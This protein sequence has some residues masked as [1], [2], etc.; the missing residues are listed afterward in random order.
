MQL[1]LKNGVGASRDSDPED[2]RKAKT[3]LNILGELKPDPELGLNGFVDR[4][5]DTVVRRFQ[6]RRGLLVTGEIQPGDETEEAINAELTQ[7]K[8]KRGQVGRAGKSGSALIS[9]AVSA[10]DIDPRRG[11][12]TGDEDE[13]RFA[14]PAAGRTERR[15]ST[16]S[17]F[18]P[19]ANAV[20][21]ILNPEMRNDEAGKGW[22]GAPRQGGKKHKGVDLLAPPG[23]PVLSPVDGLIKRI[24]DPYLPTNRLHGKFNSVWIALPNG[25]TI[26]M[27][28]V[29]PT[30][31]EGDTVKG[32]Q[33][34]GIMQDRA[35]QTRDMENHVHV[36]VHDPRGKVVDPAPWLKKWGMK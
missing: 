15:E 36:Q 8:R 24:G 28:Y 33:R 18:A 16:T 14:Q 5:F 13:T 10:D 21:P 9:G 35:A 3:V 30:V 4:P 11:R 29:A 7:M 26:R 31:K 2:V 27:F 34:I 23:A 19:P 20:S 22:F 12:S 25:S 6:K 32:G 17:P 1:K